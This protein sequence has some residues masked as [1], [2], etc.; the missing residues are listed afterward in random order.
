MRR[1]TL[2]SKLPTIL[3]AGCSVFFSFS[4]LA[5]RLP[6]TACLLSL[7]SLP[8]AGAGAADWPVC[9]GGGCGVSVAM[10]SVLS[11]NAELMVTRD[12]SFSRCACHNAVAVASEQQE[13]AIDGDARC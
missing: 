8:A 7:L 11:E 6:W 13:T 3:T 4:S 10:S 12:S 2:R 1:H 9:C 5:L